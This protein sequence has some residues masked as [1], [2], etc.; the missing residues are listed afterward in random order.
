[1]GESGS[2]KTSLLNVLGGRAG[3]GWV[4]GDLSLNGRPFSPRRN[5]HLVGYVP[6]AHVLYKELTVYEN[7]ACAAGHFGLGGPGEVDLKLDL[8]RSGIP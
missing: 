8:G 3:Y 1:M 4:T 7:L 6:Q 2:G 5:R